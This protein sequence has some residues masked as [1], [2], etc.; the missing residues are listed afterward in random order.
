MPSFLLKADTYSSP[1][2]KTNAG[3]LFIWFLESQKVFFRNK[4]V[5][6]AISREILLS[7]VLFSN[8]FRLIATDFIRELEED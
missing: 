8:R 2:F 1:G 7:Q 6:G 4:L 3:V 5:S